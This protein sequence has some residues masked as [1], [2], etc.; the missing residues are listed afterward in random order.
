MAAAT[1]AETIKPQD[2][3]SVSLEIP[4]YQRAYAWTGDEAEIFFSDIYDDFQRFL[5]EVKTKSG[6]PVLCRLGA[7][8]VYEH[9]S[10]DDVVLRIVDGQQRTSTLFLLMVVILREM[11]KRDI[12]DAAGLKDLLVIRKEIYGC[13]KTRPR[14]IMRDAEEREFLEWLVTE[15]LNPGKDYEEKAKEIFQAHQAGKDSRKRFYHKT[16]ARP[17]SR[18][19]DVLDHFRDKM[20]GILSVEGALSPE[21]ILGYMGTFLCMRVRII[22][23]ISPSEIEAIRDFEKMNNRGVSLSTLD[24]LRA[25]VLGAS[26]HHASETQILVQ[27]RFDEVA[28]ALPDA[29]RPRAAFLRAHALAGS[30]WA[31]KEQGTERDALSHLQR[32]ETSGQRISEDPKAFMQDLRKSALHYARLIACEGISGI[33]SPS[34]KAIDDLG[35][36]KICITPLMAARSMPEDVFEKFARLIETSA[37]VFLMGG[38][39]QKVLEA[40]FFSIID[41][42]RNIRDNKALDRFKSGTLADFLE[43][44]RAT[45]SANLAGLDFSIPSASRRLFYVLARIADATRPKKTN[46]YPDYMELSMLRREKKIDIEHILPKEQSLAL[47]DYA[48]DVDWIGNL[49][50]LEK[51]LNIAAGTLPH[52]K[53]KVWYAQSKIFITKAMGQK[54]TGDC[55][56][57]QAVKEYNIQEPRENWSLKEILDRGLSIMDLIEVVWELDGWRLGQIARRRFPDEKMTS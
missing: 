26:R 56:F 15:G 48:S 38:R 52:D 55:Q 50:L 11:H 4:P 36:Q 13:F 34:L 3:K 41:E 37:F 19:V 29:E 17:L 47:G 57:A 46:T 8:L 32:L 49:T 1:L 5:E 14:L 43:Q 42:V 45:A 24:I 16:E 2:L 39:Q 40:W 27:E 51:E 30:T 33:P 23:M 22:K 10:G 12:P 28:R 25:F 20:S 18:M 6:D 31:L 9:R 53:K 21:D 7:M 44:H 35:V 54:W